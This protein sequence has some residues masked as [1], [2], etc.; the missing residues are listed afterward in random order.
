MTDRFY[1]T[2]NTVQEYLKIA[3]GYDGRQLI[4]KLKEFMPV[5][6]TVLELGSGPGKDLIIL[7]ESYQATGSDYSTHFLDLI[8][9]KHP[10]VELLR[11]DAITLTTNKT[12]DGIYSNK[13]LHHLSDNDLVESINNQNKLLKDNGI[14]CHSFWKGD[15]TEEMHGLLF[16]Y[17]AEN[18]V[19]ELFAN[20][21]EIVLLE[22]YG[23]MDKNDSILIIGKKK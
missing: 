16:N 12:F 2:E 1:H 4:E 20:Q 18:E 8:K 14:V 22:T 7:S 11:L 21:F 5:N 15:H 19:E 3:E 23:E 9:D 10:N 13:V 17:H 6:S